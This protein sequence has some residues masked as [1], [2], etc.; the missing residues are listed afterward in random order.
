[1][2]LERLENLNRSLERMRAAWRIRYPVEDGQTVSRRD[3]DFL[4][5][6]LAEVVDADEAALEDAGTL[7]LTDD[8]EV[9][10]HFRDL[11]EALGTDAFIL[12]VVNQL[13]MITRRKSSA[14]KPSDIL[15]KP[16]LKRLRARKAGTD[17][18]D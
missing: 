1:M 8:I 4:R 3:R 17:L 11:E 6:V 2:D 16:L 5:G 9:R 18:T 10:Q 13:H 7:S 12:S 15:A 14:F